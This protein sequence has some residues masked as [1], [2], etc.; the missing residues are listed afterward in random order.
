MK[1]PNGLPMLSR[2]TSIQFLCLLFAA[3]ST[4][5][6]AILPPDP[7]AIKNGH[8][9]SLNDYRRR[10]G[11]DFTYD[12]KHLNKE[13][14]RTE[15]EEDCQRS[16]EHF[17]KQVEKNRKF[18]TT[19]GRESLA[20]ER[21][22]ENTGTFNVLVCLMKWK[23][24]AEANRELP[25]F[26]DYDILFNADVA[27][28]LDLAGSVN[29]WFKTSSYGDFDVRSTVIDFVVTDNTEAFYANP[30]MG[31]SLAIIPAFTPVLDALDNGGSFDFSPFD[32]DGDNVIDMVVFLHSGYDG[33][34]G[35]TDAFGATSDQRIASHAR[36]A[37]SLDWQSS[38]GFSLGSF[39]V[40]PAMRGIQNVNINKIGVI[41]HELIHL[42]GMP[43]L[44]DTDGPFT[45]SSGT[46]GGI[47]NYDI[48]VSVGLLAI[49]LSIV[50]FLN[51]VLR[52]FV[53]RPIQLV[54]GTQS[55]FLVT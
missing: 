35:N 3:L 18:L 28:A 5:T 32:Q 29:T 12:T 38:T 11:I 30:N 8:F 23:D 37:S 42:F 47:A 36:S 10:L 17:G 27:D 7:D 16:D 55:H 2:H 39:V 6:W 9:E 4:S 51:N 24:H 33:V 40:A 48:M 1:P 49:S 53:S 52:M 25:P 50:C 14:C 31:R 26:S 46:I 43:D 21:K 44:Y 20:N 41:V 15:T 13:F 34:N 45:P 22:L 54:R 19:A